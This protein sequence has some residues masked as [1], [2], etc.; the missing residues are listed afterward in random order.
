MNDVESDHKV[1]PR[2]VLEIRENPIVDGK[3]DKDN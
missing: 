3:I 1:N 2:Q